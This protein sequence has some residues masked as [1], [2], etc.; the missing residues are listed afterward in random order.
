MKEGLISS[1]DLSREDILYLI[2]RA[3]HFRDG[4]KVAL[5]DKIVGL[6]FLENSSRTRV[7]FEMAAKRL[8]MQTVFLGPEGSS[9]QKG[10]SELDTARVLSCNGADALVVRTGM[11]GLPA[12]MASITQV[13]VISAGESLR[14]HPSQGLL[15]AFTLMD[16]FGSLEGKIISIVGDIEHSRVA[17][18]NFHIL[19]TLGAEVRFVG[20][21]HI[22]SLADGLENADAVMALRVQKERGAKGDYSAFGLSHETMRS[23]KPNAVVLHPLP[24]NRGVEITSELADDPQRSLIWKQ[25]ENGLF[26]RMAIYERVLA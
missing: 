24:M 25:M 12:A 11:D 9:L 14:D 20:P 8:G 3:R 21:H 18:S 6:I 2:K 10:E 26:I 7:S 15:D 16:R 5:K 22:A 1:A 13:P 19:R 23:A 4:E 17:Q